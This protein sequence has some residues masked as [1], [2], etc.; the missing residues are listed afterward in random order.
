[1]IGTERMM[2]QSVS[3][4]TFTLVTGSRG[5]GGTT[6]AAHGT[7]APVMSTPLPIDN[8]PYMAPPAPAN[9]PNPYLG[10]QAQMCIQMEGF[11]SYSPGMVQFMTNIFDIGDGWVSYD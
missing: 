10:K 5:A 8:N 7:G 9:T 6:A 4:T 2:V 1:V 11:M 3:G